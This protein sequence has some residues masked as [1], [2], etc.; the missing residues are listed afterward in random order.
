MPPDQL[1]DIVYL[2][3]LLRDSND[4]IPRLKEL[5]APYILVANECAHLCK[6]VECLEDNAHMPSPSKDLDGHVYASLHD[7]GY[8]ILD[9]WLNKDDSSEYNDK[10]MRDMTPISWRRSSRKPS[11][12]GHRSSFPRHRISAAYM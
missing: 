10:E 12:R 2:A 1:S 4:R 5:N 3:K 7:I 6:K 9:G 11:V 8:S